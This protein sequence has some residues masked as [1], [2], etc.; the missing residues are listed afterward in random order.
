MWR[1]NGNH[2]AVVGTANLQGQII[3][4]DLVID[5]LA[6]VGTA[7]GRLDERHGVVCQQGQAKR[8]QRGFGNGPDKNQAAI[9]PYVLSSS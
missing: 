6:A 4:R 1:G 7:Q 9:A 3:A 5:L 2:H 8:K